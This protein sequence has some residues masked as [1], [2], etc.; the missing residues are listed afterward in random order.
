MN[1]DL[2]RFPESRALGTIGSF[3]QNVLR[4]AWQIA[5]LL[6]VALLMLFEPVLGFVLC[7]LA[8]VGDRVRDS[9][10]FRRCT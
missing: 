10:I 4:I 9:Q 8:L 6:I 7:G 1:N 3:L 5:R 2:E